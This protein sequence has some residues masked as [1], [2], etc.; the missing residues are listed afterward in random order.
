MLPIT[1]PSCPNNVV[2]CQIH[3]QFSRFSFSLQ[4]ILITIP[5]SKSHTTS[6]TQ[7]SSA[8]TIKILQPVLSHLQTLLRLTSTSTTMSSTDLVHKFGY[9][10]HKPT[11]TL[12]SRRQEID[13]SI[14][15]LKNWLNHA[16]DDEEEA[17]PPRKR[18]RTDSCVGPP[19][20][21][22]ASTGSI[23]RKKMETTRLAAPLPAHLRPS[24]NSTHLG[25]VTYESRRDVRP[26]VFESFPIFPC[27]TPEVEEEPM[28]ME[29]RMEFVREK[30]VEVFMKVSVVGKMMRWLRWERGSG[31]V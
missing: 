29:E 11:H 30:Q 6:Y 25:S 17:T 15:D 1:L 27:A 9:T 12:S 10:T 19:A 22:I 3:T 20:I 23:R 14:R 4:P 7:S 5:S 24:N 8:C 16:E 31:C 18:T 28:A 13:V 2:S 21:L 26:Q